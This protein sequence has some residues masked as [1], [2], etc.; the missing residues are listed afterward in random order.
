MDNVNR[1]NLFLINYRIIILGRIKKIF[2]LQIS[3]INSQ[4]ESNNGDIAPLEQIPS[5][6]VDQCDT[7]QC[8]KADL[9]S[10]EKESS[11]CSITGNLTLD[12][13][14]SNSSPSRNQIENQTIDNSVNSNQV[15]TPCNIDFKK[16][17]YLKS[18]IKFMKSLILPGK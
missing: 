10:R 9:E 13:N 8:E 12:L 7:Q 17:E 4:N 6:S 18:C 1:Y 15:H 5:T 3:I 2:Y 11:L 16:C 14:R